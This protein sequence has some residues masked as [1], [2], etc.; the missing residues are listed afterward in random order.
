MAVDRGIILHQV[1]CMGVMGTG[2]A[3]A[4]RDKYPVVFSAYTKHCFGK[5]PWSL[6]GNFQLV[7]VSQ[8]LYIGNVFGQQRY[9]RSTRQTD[10]DAVQESLIQMRVDIHPHLEHL[11]I[12]YP[13]MG[14]VNAGG[15]W[16]IV[17]AILNECLDGLDHKL[18][19]L[20]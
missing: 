19:E 1:N 20:R 2:I 5:T 11:P 13:K 7:Q 16:N 18:M 17:S 4:I 8:D 3:K 14:C 10:Y 12:F 9:G 15:D 6:L